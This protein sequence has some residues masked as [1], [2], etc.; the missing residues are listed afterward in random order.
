MS[1]IQG[2][3][4]SN[5]L[6][7]CAIVDTHIQPIMGMA[8]W[9]TENTSATPQVFPLFMPGSFRPLARDTEKASIASPTPSR[10]LLKK[11]AKLKSIF[12]P[13]CDKKSGCGT[14]T[15][16]VGAKEKDSMYGCPSIHES[17]KL[18]QAS[19]LGSMLTCH[20]RATLATPSH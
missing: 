7:R 10:M 5:A 9:N 14:T 2:M 18:K 17:R 1:A 13:P 20:V 4:R 6:K 12:V 15:P 11:N 3:N 8:N 19:P 16:G